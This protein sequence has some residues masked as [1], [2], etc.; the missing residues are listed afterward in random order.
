MAR[1]KFSVA[2]LAGLIGAAL[3]VL[4]APR[5][6]KE[7][8]EDLKR[9]ADEAK[10]TGD[11]TTARMKD[12]L[13]ESAAEVKETVKRSSKEL[14]DLADEAKV[15]ASRI[16]DDAK[17]TSTSVADSTKRSLGQNRDEIDETTR[18]ITPRRNRDK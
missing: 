7:T 15:R 14:G 12:T 1:N 3:G 10:K 11:H 16:A 18:T 9:R 8:R 6:G 13:R 2:V 17:K 4:F 5:S